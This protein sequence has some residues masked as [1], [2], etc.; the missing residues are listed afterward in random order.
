VSFS[1]SFSVSS[2]TARLSTNTLDEV[3]DGVKP[4]R[5]RARDRFASRALTS[6]YSL[7]SRLVPSP[8]TTGS[9]ESN[10]SRKSCSSSVVVTL[11]RTGTAASSTHRVTSRSLFARIFSAR[12]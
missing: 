1:V 9:N 6:A 5:A 10:S 7:P 11:P 3:S 8:P 2:D 12:R 4:C